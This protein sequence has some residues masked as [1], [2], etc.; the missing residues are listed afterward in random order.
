MAVLQTCMA[1]QQ[2]VC[3]CRTVECGITGISLLYQTGFERNKIEKIDI[4]GKTS[5]E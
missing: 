2:K 3:L 5:K 1:E 4:R